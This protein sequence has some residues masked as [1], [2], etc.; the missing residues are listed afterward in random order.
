MATEP[1]TH[2][3]A[4][5]APGPAAHETNREDTIPEKRPI[6]VRQKT[7][8]ESGFIPEAL[9]REIDKI[10]LSYRKLYTTLNSGKGVWAFTSLHQE[11]PYDP[12]R[13]CTTER[14]L[15]RSATDYRCKTHQYQTIR[16]TTSERVPPSGQENK[17]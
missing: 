13:E 16:L 6:P 8:K 14:T 3:I 11:R 12:R 7:K 1:Y 17:S 15:P 4:L 10:P 5:H 2:D 9:L